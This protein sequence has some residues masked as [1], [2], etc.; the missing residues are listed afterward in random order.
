M[1]DHA[2]INVRLA[3]VR[4][5]CGALALGIGVIA[6]PAAAEGPQ[7]R[8]GLWEISISGMPQ[9]HTQCFTPEMVKDVKN[10]AQRG[11]KSADCKPSN[12]KVTGNTRTFQVS[13]TKPNKYDATISL[14]M[15]GPDNFTMTQNYSVDAGGKAQKGTLTMSYRRLG[16]CK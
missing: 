15:N 8:P 9:K 2:T 3:V 10:L 12:E 4:A 1:R 5:V 16:D 13:C 7:L 11:E 14:T 6:T